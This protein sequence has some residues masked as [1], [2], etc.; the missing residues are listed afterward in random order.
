VRAEDGLLRVAGIVQ[1]LNHRSPCLS[2]LQPSFS[3]ILD[4][5]NATGSHD[6]QGPRTVPK[7]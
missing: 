3:V 1:A 6:G 4:H 2:Q 7:A 5:R